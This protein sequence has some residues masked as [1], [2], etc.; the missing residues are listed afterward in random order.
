MN[1]GVTVVLTLAV[2][3]CTLW[4]PAPATSQVTM[5]TIMTAPTPCVR[6]VMKTWSPN[7]TSPTVRVHIIKVLSSPVLCTFDFRNSASCIPS[8]TGITGNLLASAIGA[9]VTMNTGC[10]WACYCPSRTPITT[11]GPNDGLPVELMDFS[12][13]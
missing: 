1:R 2:A 7:R 6:S 3:L 4:S 8:A 9:A 5:S 11:S 13:E 10:A 12:I